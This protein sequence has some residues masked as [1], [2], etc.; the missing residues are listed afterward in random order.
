LHLPDFIVVGGGTAGSVLAGRLTA[1]ARHSVLLIEA[2]P[3]PSNSN[4]GIPA[5]FGKLFRSDHDWAFESEPQMHRGRRIFTPRGK[6]LGGSSNMNAQIHQWC[7]PSDFDEW[8]ASGARGWG[9]KDVAPV[10]AAQENWRGT[11]AKGLRGRSGPM[12]VEENRHAH[13]LAHAFVESA[14]TYGLSGTDDYN[15]SA[16]EGA[17]IVQIA[18][19][20]GKRFSA[21][22]A[23]LKPALGRP[24]LQVETSAHATRLVFDGTRC[25]GVEVRQ[26]GQTRQFRAGRGVILS[27]GAFGSPQ[28]LMLSGLGPGEHLKAMGINVLRDLAGVGA[29]LQDHAMAGL[30]FATHRQD[31]LKSAE[32]I[33]NILRYLFLKSGPLAS[34]AVEAFAF[35]RILRQSTATDVELLFAPFEWRNQGLE[36]PKVHGFSVASLVLKPRSRGS[37]RLHGPDPATAPR[38]D[39][40][41]LTDADD[42]EVM[43]GGLRLIRQIATAAPL[44]SEVTAELAP[45]LGCESDEALLDFLADNVQT[46]YHPTSTCRMG[47]GEDAVVTSELAVRGLEGLWI[48]DASVMPSVPRGHT[49]AVVAMIANRAATMLGA[50]PA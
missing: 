50:R 12:L 40:G 1:D 20:N 24:S 8:A 19:R 11:D 37:V 18:H 25:S 48:A 29:N 45:S 17:W 10:F 15:G 35:T 9:W 16:Y 30:T 49:N 44:S 3:K 2:G 42:R 14:R 13:P 4:V 39:F 41:M 38:I 46:C 43:L 21:W 47:D 32:S 26:G 28:L 5:G 22:D 34:N 36:P 7:H 27:A 6:M 31:T 33:G 23:Y